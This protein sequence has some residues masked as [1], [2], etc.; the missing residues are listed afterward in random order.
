MRKLFVPT[1]GPSDW[2]RLLADSDKH[3]KEGYSAYESA[4]AWEA[5]RKSDRG[6]PSELA[7][8][9]DSHPSF[10]G[11]SLLLGIPEH[12]VSIKGGG[13]ASQTDFWALL[14]TP[15]GIVSTA[16]EAKAGEEFD[17][18]VA[19]WLTK[20]KKGSR[21]PERLAELCRMWGVESHAV[22]S[23][24]YQLMHRPITAI[25]EARRFR[26][27]AALFIIHAF[28]RKADTNTHSAREY[29]AW[30]RALKIDA[31]H[32]GLQFA[33]EYE[34]VP[35]WMA[36]VASPVASEATVRAAV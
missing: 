2:R 9:L 21:K 17:D 23:C 19:V 33:G 27:S 16:I 31:S 28:N 13:H 11:A 12:Q 20:S 6:L 1:M 24:R 8:I 35:L 32:D 14:E 3:W 30:R 5:A 26:A 10:S 15:I 29:A 22:Q 25:L 34:G 4:V 36:W 7:A 18:T